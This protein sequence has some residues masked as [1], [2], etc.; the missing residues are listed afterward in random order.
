MD[1]A[2]GWLGL[3]FLLLGGGGR[4]QS[5]PAGRRAPERSPA[6]LP[7]GQQT[8]TAP[9]PLPWPQVTPTGLPAFPGSGWEYDEP[10]PAAVQQRASQLVSELWRQGS[11]SYRIEQTAG[12]WIAFRAE[13]VKGPQGNHKGVVAYRL[14]PKALPAGTTTAQRPK[15]SPAAAPAVR[16]APSPRVVTSPGVPQPA[17]PSAPAAATPVSWDVKVG[18]A[19]NSQLAL[20]TL[21]RGAGIKPKAPDANVRILQQKLGIAADGQFGAGTEAAVKTFQRRAGLVQDGIVG[22]QTWTALFAVRA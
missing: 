4:A 3:L 9:P 5:S 16:T 14:K 18:P 13:L 8:S 17:R 21:R 7:A 20:P 1:T 11:G 19:Q 15:P 12:R 10:P 2:F 6:Q 22:T